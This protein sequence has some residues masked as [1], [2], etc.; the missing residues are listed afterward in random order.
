MVNNMVGISKM[1]SKT[2][3]CIK[4]NKKQGVTKCDK[5]NKVTCIDCLTIIPVPPSVSP[6]L[7]KIKHR[8][9]A[10]AKHNSK[11]NSGENNDL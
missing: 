8:T 1:D 7:I 2:D 5:C 4:C 6:T 10:S 3:R 9:C 11:T